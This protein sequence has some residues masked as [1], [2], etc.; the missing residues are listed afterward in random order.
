[1]DEELKLEL[2]PYLAEDGIDLNDAETMPADRSAMRAALD[3]AIRR[4]NAALLTPEGDAR[5][6][7]VVALRRVVEAI[8]SDDN[9]LATELMDDIE[10]VSPDDSAPTVSACIGVT[11]H[12]LDAW[13]IGEDQRV[14]AQ[15]AQR[16]RLPRG[17]WVGA[18]TAT[19]ILDLAAKG[20]ALQSVASLVREQGG[21][22]LLYGSALALAAAVNAWSAAH[23]IP[24][25]QLAREVIA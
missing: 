10:P 13:L 20:R 14:P 15:L 7:A 3:R 5:E 21:N 9:P 18:R 24:V 23:A 1:M 8:C 6:R 11:L 22:H 2:A 12:L 19:D 25:P 16:T 17:P 4:R